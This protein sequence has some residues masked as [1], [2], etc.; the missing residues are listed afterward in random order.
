MQTREKKILLAERL[1]GTEMRREIHF[2]RVH[3]IGK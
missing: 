3:D 2:K 1:I